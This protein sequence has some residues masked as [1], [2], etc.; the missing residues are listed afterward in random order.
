M[1]RRCQRGHNHTN[2]RLG[3]CHHTNLDDRHTRAITSRAR[4]HTINSRGQ[5]RRQVPTTSRRRRHRNRRDKPTRQGRRFPSRFRVATPISLYHI[6]V[7]H[8]RKQRMLLRVR[9]M[10]RTYRKKRSRHPVHVRRARLI[11]HTVINRR[12]SLV[13]RRR[14]HRRTRR[15]HLLRAR[16]RPRRNR[17]HGCNNSS[18]TR[19]QRPKRRCHIRGVAK[20][21]HLPRNFS[22]VIPLQS[23]ERCHQQSTHGLLVNRRTTKRR[24]RR[25]RR[26]GHHR[27]SSRRMSRALARGPRFTD[28]LGAVP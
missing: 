26:H 1:R 22:R 17:N 12:G 6:M 9:S 13:Q 7:Y 15:R 23:I 27:S 25:Q 3:L 5:P 10:R 18:H 19:H 24:M 14:R 28:L 16:A 21:Q 20:R 11:S 2:H 8:Q 4:I